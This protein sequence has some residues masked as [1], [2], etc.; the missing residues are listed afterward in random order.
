M[1]NPQNWKVVL[2]ALFPS[3]P[4]EKLMSS[5]QND[6]LWGKR[7][8]KE[9]RKLGK[10]VRLVILKESW[11]VGTVEDIDKLARRQVRVTKEHNEECKRLLA[12][13]GIPVVTVSS[14][15]R[16]VSMKLTARLLERLRLNVLNL[17]VLER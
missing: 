9:K 11:W 5:L 3:P 15:L 17:L 6:L 14:S 1:V 10:L 13:M 16:S 8:K 12:L 7:R 2:W 4:D